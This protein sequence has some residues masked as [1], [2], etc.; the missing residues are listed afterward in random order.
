[1]FFIAVRRRNDLRDIVLSEN[2]IEEVEIGIVLVLALVIVGD[3]WGR[4]LD[5]IIYVLDGVRDRLSVLHIHVRL[6]TRIRLVIS[7]TVDLDGRE[8]GNTFDI[9]PVFFEESLWQNSEHLPCI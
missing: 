2:E 1:M 7:T 8:V 9:R 4:S 3:V 6:N 5:A